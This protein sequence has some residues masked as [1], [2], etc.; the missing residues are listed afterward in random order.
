MSTGIT[1]NLR[2]S[3]YKEIRRV[4][5]ITLEDTLKKGTTSPEQL[6]YVSS[7]VAG[8]IVVYCIT[9]TCNIKSELSINKK[10]TTY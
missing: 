6:I 9:S 7:V 8:D 4:E 10:L 3:N 1:S 2:R 5:I